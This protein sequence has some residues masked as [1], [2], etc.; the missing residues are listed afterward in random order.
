MQTAVHPVVGDPW[1]G[2]S[3]TLRVPQN[4]VAGRVVIFLSKSGALEVR[5][6]RLERFTAAESFA[7]LTAEMDRHYSFFEHKGVDWNQL[8]ESHRAQADAASGPD[9]FID[10]VRPMLAEL[11]D[12]HV[13]LVRPDGEQVPTFVSGY[14]PNFDYRAVAAQ[15]EDLRRIGKVGLAGR[16]KEGFGYLAV[17]SLS[18]DEAT[19]RTLAEALVSMSDAPGLMIDIRGNGGGDENRARQLLGLLATEPVVYARSRIRSGP[20]AGDFGRPRARRLDP[21]G[22]ASYQ[23][24][25][26]GLIGPGCTS[27]G[28]AMAMMLAALPNATLI[29]QPTRGA[30][31]NPQPLEL[32]NGVVAYFSRWQS[33]RPDGTPIEGR[34]VEPDVTVA[35]DGPGDPTFA[36]AVELLNE[37]LRPSA[38]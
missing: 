32:P 36:K 17:A 22:D 35:H 28:E 2:Q 14:R 25:I 16:T 20:R 37:R 21:V 26:V 29:G 18:F 23:G 27:S 12:L 4:A 38:P 30:S 5:D 7:L 11:K 31:G 15:L 34:G 3:V 8:T 33:L 10:A 6:V 1:V 24:P 13:F 19:M 9:A